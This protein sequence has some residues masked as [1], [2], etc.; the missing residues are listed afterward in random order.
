MR[1]LF[2][3]FLNLFDSDKVK[4][5]KK[6]AP[7]DEIIIYTPKGYY[8]TINGNRIYNRPLEVIVGNNDPVSRKI[9]IYFQLSG[10]ETVHFFYKYWEVKDYILLNISNVIEG[11]QITKSKEELESELKTAIANDNFEMAS[12]INKKLKELN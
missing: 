12:L 5:L 9:W 6:L 2:R 10:G 3:K 7:N 8:Q 1:K 11:E 4:L